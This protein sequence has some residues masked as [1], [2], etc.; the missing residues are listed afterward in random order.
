MHEFC[1]FEVVSE[2]LSYTGKVI[3]MQVVAILLV[4]THPF[5]QTPEDSG[6]EPLKRATDEG[7]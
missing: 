6:N 4:P 1:Q 3:G 2:G 7:W 5:H